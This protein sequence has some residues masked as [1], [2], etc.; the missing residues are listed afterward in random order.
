MLLSSSCEYVS[1]MA[2]ENISGNLRKR[3]KIK[4]GQ[5]NRL[6][7]RKKCSENLSYIAR[8]IFKICCSDF[9]RKKT[10]QEIPR[11]FIGLYFLQG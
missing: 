3:A 10:P 1:E 11:N 2:E 6:L 4:I 9:F 5:L 8:S 7:K